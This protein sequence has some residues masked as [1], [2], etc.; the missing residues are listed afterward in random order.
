MN[1][2]TGVVWM[3]R[4]KPD[5][6]KSK[7]LRNTGRQ[8][9]AFLAASC[10]V[11][12]LMFS[13][14][15]QTVEQRVLPGHVPA[16]VASLHL[17][18]LQTLSNSMSLHL[19]IGLPLRNQTALANLLRQLYDPA[20]PN[21]HHYLTPE[22]FAEEFGA[23]EQDY[24][25][26]V[27]FARTNGL[28]VTATYPNH[29]LVDVSGTVANIEKA[30]HVTMEVYQH[31]TENRTFYAPD[32]EP[33]ID[34]ALPILSVSGLNDYSLPHTNYKPEPLNKI[35]P[36]A[37]SGPD[38]S[39][40]GNDFR[41]AYVP[42]TTLT[43]AG[44][45]VGLLQ[46]DAFYPNDITAYENQIGMTGGGPQL[47]VVPVDGGVSTPGTGNGEVSLDIEMVLSMSP[48]V[49]KIYVYEAPNPSPW[50]DI[51]NRMA[52]DDFAKQLSS[53]WG[54]GSPDPNAEQ[55]FKQ[56][57]AQGQ[58]FF[59]ASGDSD[60][61]TG[62]IPFP[63]DST[64]ITEVG[65]TTLT[66]GSRSSY[67][68]E[69]VWNW[70][71]EIGSA[72]DGVGSSGGISTY[73]AIPPWQM[74]IDMTACKGSTTMRN[75]PDVALTGDNVWV[76]SG[77]G[78]SGAVG[79]TSCAAP[80]WAGF[81]ALVNEQAANEGHSPVG[82]LNPAL[83][84]IAKG[85]DYDN[86]FHDVTTG[87]NTWSGSPN[88]F[89]AV[90]GYDLC[91]GLGTPNG[92]N[93][94]NA[95][96]GLPP[97]NGF[98][99]ISVNPPNKSVLLNG[100]TQDVFV[101]V[102]DV[103]GVTNA[104]VTASIAG[105]T[106]LTFQNDGQPPDATSGDDVYSAKFV[107]PATGNSL[108]MVVAAS[109]T[110]EIGA[111]NTINYF[112]APLPL[113]DNFVNATKVPAAGATYLAN[114]TFATIET[115]EPA[116][117]GDT[118]AA[119]SLWWAWNPPAS[120]NVLINTIGSKV[121]NVLA[122]YIGNSLTSLQPV[123]ATNS[124][125]TQYKPA[126]VEF[127][128]QAGTTYR[129]ALAS[130][131]TN[132][133]GTVGLQ[134]IPG[135]QPDTNAPVVSVTSPLS[136]YT[137]TN[138]LVTLTGV[139]SDPAPNVSGVNLVLVSV[140]NVTTVA[141]GTTNWTQ[142]TG[143]QP[144]LNTIQVESIDASGNISTP[145]TVQINYLVPPPGNDFFA[146]A[147]SLTANPQVD[148]GSNVGATKE[149]GEPDIAGNAGGASIWWK[150]KAPG[151]GVLTLNTTNSTFDTLLGLYTGPDVASLTTIADNDDAYPG[152]LGGFSLLTQAVRAG[153]IYYIAVDGYD[154]ATGTVS[155]SYSFVPATVYRLTVTNTG[156]GT[157]QLMT[158]NALGGDS[159]P[160][161]QSG[162][163]ASGS[164][165]MLTAIPDAD[166]QFDIWNGD[167]LSLDNPLTVTVGGNMNIMANFHAKTY[168]DGFESG[169]L[170]QLP[171]TTAGD[172]PW[173]VQTNVVDEGQYAA[174]SGVIGNSQTSSLMLT[175]N[176][177]AGT[178]SFDYKVSSEPGWDFLNFYVDGTLL[179]QWSGEVGW[180]NYTFL[181]S[182]GNHTLEWTYAKDPTISSG[183]DAA[184]IDDVNLPIV[185]S[186]NNTSVAQLQLQRQS[187]GGFF[188]NLVGQA[189]QQ[190]IIQ[191]STNLIN[192]QDIS[193]N[194]A[195]GGL[196]R[197]PIPVNESNQAE[198]YR[199]V[200]P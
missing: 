52:E 121:D 30:F 109:A 13:S 46:F 54:G 166:S 149:V 95:L 21:Y 55:I 190:Y 26:V 43:G 5:T 22:Q 138:H 170:F 126:Q 177:L 40:E 161:A 135:G 192:W 137:S 92:A 165:V 65:A 42:G 182:A 113:N 147:Y 58:T 180:A 56:M 87:D 173:T 1:H 49:S 127:N 53:S 9:V 139:A 186:T 94:I 69:T 128:V 2:K 183:L 150:Y 76:I 107:V 37:G 18:P 81:T 96:S 185:L 41:N 60:A 32:V 164:M 39:Y 144:G 3:Q 100:S 114:N 16:A 59:N 199:A 11:L 146:N 45:N 66:T 153:Q 162:D 50:V 89:H 155:L 163:F 85:S 83:Y 6:M 168:T 108:S 112:L 77:N 154:G 75:V 103:Y 106:N 159:I 36:N 122:V 152:A 195:T 79:G 88:L 172:A 105:V 4:F 63:S 187:D 191:A 67:K 61:F 169:N 200:V 194:A 131:N 73:Y 35:T 174:R 44:Q 97:R 178:G 160:P 157:V 98:L 24:Q 142:L 84:Y 48:G 175:A 130:I 70:G 28:T 64:N 7:K 197:L 62:P 74:G 34:A 80:L 167:A 101:T 27:N 57:A 71:N 17:Q 196:I 102:N 119:A 12:F 20:S 179:Q 78:Q 38:G 151:D 111:S 117:D 82:F 133:L 110:N 90:T 118:D 25:T 158:T 93:L 14:S 104:T 181:L 23:S 10:A 143:L 140:N 68:S 134:I 198:F 19:A 15:A 136:G 29:L 72:Y 148:T 141:S 176:F 184:F 129:I 115:N 189:G 86:C 51:L 8:Q 132:S 124:N 116:H 125:L 47:V 171:W 193:T 33:T 156:N 99:Q 120:T 188:M 123:T 31:P 145:A 91:T